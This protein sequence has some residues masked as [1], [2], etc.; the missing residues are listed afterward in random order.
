MILRTSLQQARRI[1]LPF[2]VGAKYHHQLIY[3]SHLRLFGTTTASLTKGEQQQQQNPFEKF[4]TRETI[5]S[6]LRKRE[7]AKTMVSGGESN[8]PLRFDGRV[9][10][11][12]GAGGGL[13]RAYALAFAER[14]AKVVVNDLGGS[15]TGEGGKS[16][17][18][19]DVVVD[20]IKARNGIAVAN[21]G[22]IYIYK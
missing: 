16:S 4:A 3:N 11:V 18:A 17:R 2:E 14:G 10:V 19:A 6:Y 1:L 13:G 22:S 15:M 7:L 12:T 5:A 8:K 9:V 21:Y 20:E